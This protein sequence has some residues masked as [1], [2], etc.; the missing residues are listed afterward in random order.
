MVFVTR[1][2]PSLLV[3]PWKDGLNPKEIIQK[4][5]GIQN[6]L[7]IFPEDCN[8]EEDILEEDDLMDLFTILGNDF[9]QLSSVTI[10]CTIHQNPNDDSSSLIGSFYGNNH[11]SSSRHRALSI[12]PLKAITSLLNGKNRLFNLT[13]VQA[14]LLG[15]G[16][17]VADF[18]SAIRLHPTLHSLDCTS[19]VF[20][21]ESHLRELQA[22]VQ[23]RIQ[24]MQHVFI[25]Q[26]IILLGERSAAMINKNDAD[27]GW[28]FSNPLLCNCG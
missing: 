20:S 4:R 13:L 8:R 5:R 17:E 25:D 2:G 16:Q 22:A 9:S 11:H 18:I 21:K 6:V 14:R 10:S 19:C 26:S 15:S 7:I 27:E 28:L 23:S 12:P 24:V 3:S 1:S